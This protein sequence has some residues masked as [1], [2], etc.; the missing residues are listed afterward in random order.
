MTGKEKLALFIDGSNLYRTTRALGFDVD[1]KRLLRVFQSRGYLLRAFYYT[2]LLEEEERQSLR[3]LVDWLEY[4]G[5]TVVTKAAK[6]FVDQ[7]GGRRIK[8]SMDIELAVDALELAPR[9]DQMV[10]VSGDGNFTRLVEA[11]QQQGVRVTVVS[12]VAP[13]MIAGGLRR[14]ADEFIDIRELQDKI[15]RDTGEQAMRA[16]TMPQL[17]RR[18]GEGSGHEPPTPEA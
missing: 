18:P 17:P 6:E 9:I 5:F 3:P 7:M 10:L 14:Q 16:P 2:T 11:M 1:Y 4:N 13:P 15:S 8:G 12:T